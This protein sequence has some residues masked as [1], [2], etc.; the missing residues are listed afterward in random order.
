MAVAP[1]RTTVAV[2]HPLPAKRPAGWV[3]IETVSN[4]C[5]P[6]KARSQPDAVNAVTD[7]ST[8]GNGNPF[9]PTFEVNF[10]D[11]CLLHDAGYS[12]ALVWD[13]INGRFVDFRGMSKKEIDDKFFNDMARLCEARI[14]AKWETALKNCKSGIGR[15][16]IVRGGFGYRERIDLAGEW[17]NPAPG[18]PVC[19]V[20]A[21]AWEIQQ[22]GRTVIASWRHGN[23][24]QKGKFVGIFINGDQAGDD[25]VEGTFTITAGNGSEV[26]GGTMTFVVS[27]GDGFDFNGAGVG[28]KMKR[29][30]RSPQGI[31]A[32]VLPPRCKNAGSKAKPAPPTQ[33]GSFVLAST[34]VTNPGAPEFT[35]D[36]AGGKAVWNHTGQ[37]GGAGKGGE[38]KVDYSFK[39]P[40]TL[41]AGK[42]FSLT[43]ALVIS[44]VLPVQPLLVEFGARAPDF[45]GRASANYPN[46]PSDTKTFAVPLSAGYKNSKEVVVV[47]AFNSIDEVIYTYRLIGA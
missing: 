27:S 10:R 35:I 6:G 9:D 42:S 44:N 34:K 45:G 32:K 1:A 21:H 2:D 39:V 43:L 4:G 17:V 31:V 29:Q 38:W 19:D 37:F 24:D 25:R 3:V 23:G 26:G 7:S 8:F 47:V 33:T 18:W 15:Y 46:P 22:K 13:K 40:K 28:G 14:P 16:L 5:G 12:G 11:A 41:V 30:G 36:A 20:G